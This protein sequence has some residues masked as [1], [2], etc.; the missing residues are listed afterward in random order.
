MKTMDGWR[1]FDAQH[2]TINSDDYLAIG[3][4]IGQDVVDFFVGLT[5][6]SAVHED[7]VQVRSPYDFYDEDGI[8]RPVFDTF[9]KENGVW[10]F[11]GECLCGE[12]PVFE[13]EAVS[14]SQKEPLS[15]LA[16]NA[17]DSV[18][19]SNAEDFNQADI[20]DNHEFE[21]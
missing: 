9:A 3:D 19:D 8:C 6:D 14:D 1:E 15:S 20:R 11:C 13:Q 7:Y 4:F 18:S 2:G 21:R 16:G 12:K 17:I 10:R 5:S